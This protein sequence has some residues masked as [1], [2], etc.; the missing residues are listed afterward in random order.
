MRSYDALIHDMSQLIDIPLSLSDRG[1]VVI[2]VDGLLTLHIEHLMQSNEVRIAA[3]L[4]TLPPDVVRERV[5]ESALRANS[6]PSV[7]NGALAFS[8]K[9]SSL[10]LFKQW[11]IEPLSGEELCDILEQFI[12]KGKEWILAL[13]EGRVEP[14]GL[15]E[16]GGE[17][18]GG[19]FGL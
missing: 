4:F 11:P 9:R 6:L 19:I 12:L 8:S 5:L 3:L 17:Q 13:E 7:C 16:Q 18:P 10:V 14:I 15:F 1:G 2:E